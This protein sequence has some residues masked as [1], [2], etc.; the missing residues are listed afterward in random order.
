MTRAIQEAY[1]LQARNP[2][3]ISVLIE[4]AKGIGLDVKAFETDLQAEQTQTQLSAEIE[5]AGNLGAEGFPSLVFLRG[6]E[7]WK[8]PIDYTDSTAMLELIEQLLDE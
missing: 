5:E 7:R 6:M 2:S 3:E 1:Y 4:I 8:I